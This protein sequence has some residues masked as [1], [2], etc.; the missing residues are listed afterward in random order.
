MDS[1]L[2][3]N[4]QLQVPHMLCTNLRFRLLHPNHSRDH[5][6]Q[7]RACLPPLRTSVPCQ[8]FLDSRLR[9]AC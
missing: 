3:H 1:L 5:R 4:N 7:Y 9:M 6:R 2:S 8:H